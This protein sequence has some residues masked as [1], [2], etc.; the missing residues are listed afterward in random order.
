MEIASKSKQLQSRES[1]VN[2]NLQDLFEREESLLNR[3][4]E[5]ESKIIQYEKQLKAT[6]E[7]KANEDNQ[8]CLLKLQID[9]LQETI[10]LKDQE[11]CK[12]FLI[13]IVK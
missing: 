9:E 10:K 5:L 3:E 11:L 13:S 7:E 6:N 1:E 8:I 4:K 2:K 12:N